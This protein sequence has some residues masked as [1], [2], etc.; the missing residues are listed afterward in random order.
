[1]IT[2][3][4]FNSKLVRLKV[5]DSEILA[6]VS[7]EFQFQIGSI[8]RN[9]ETHTDSLNRSFN[10]KLVRLKACLISSGRPSLNA[11][12]FQIGSIKSI[13]PKKLQRIFREFQFQ[14]GSIKSRLSW[15]LLGKL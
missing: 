4:G 9:I 12:Q 1:M 10:S 15:N 8:K 13:N 14:I 2:K 7:A 11:F 3:A 6:R 5:C